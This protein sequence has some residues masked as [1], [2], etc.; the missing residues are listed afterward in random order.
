MEVD[1]FTLSQLREFL[2]EHW[3]QFTEWCDCRAANGD[4]EAERIYQAIGG[5]EG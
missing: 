4:D 3:G 5:T 2:A 1:E